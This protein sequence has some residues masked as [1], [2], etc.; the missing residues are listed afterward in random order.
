MND[1]IYCKST[2]DL[3]TEMKITTDSGSQA[4]VLICDACADDASVKTAKVKYQERMVKIEEVMALAKAMGLEVVVPTDNKKLAIASSPAQEPK[5][6]I[7]TKVPD[8]FIPDMEANSN[9]IIVPTSRADSVKIDA[10]QHADS[11]AHST[12]LREYDLKVISSDQ[13]ITESSQRVQQAR[14]NGQ[15]KMSAV[16]GR[17]G[18]QMP[19]PTV[20]KDGT[21]TTL[22]SINKDVNDMALQ[23][24][25]KNFADRT[26][27]NQHNGYSRGYDKACTMCNGQQKIANRGT[28]IDCPK[29]KGSGLL[30]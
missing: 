28:M 12:N 6:E 24:R 15:V 3:N 8:I 19:I 10:I 20:R 7:I 2:T 13:S 4:V 16:E 25:F 1:C 30:Q 9:E 18:V 26:V 5:K 27:H 14:A 21:G 29:C 17:A 11:G 23:Q 22:I